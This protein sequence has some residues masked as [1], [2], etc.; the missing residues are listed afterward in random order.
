MG[1]RVDPFT[2]EQQKQLRGYEWPGN[3]R[4]LQ[5]VIERAMILTNGGELR[6]NRAMGAIQSPAHQLPAETPVA[7]GSTRV[8]TVRELEQI[9][10]ENILRALT[11][12]R[13][14]ISGEGGAARLLGIPASTLTSRMKALGIQRPALQ[15]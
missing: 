9:E 11:S 10:R 1:K 6:L 12:C 13:G 4:E 3:V 7:D 2:P 8:F 15:H 5:N 14:R